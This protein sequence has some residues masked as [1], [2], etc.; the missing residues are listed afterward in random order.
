[1]TAYVIAAIIITMNCSC[2]FAQ[3]GRLT[4]K[5]DDRFSVQRGNELVRRGLSKIIEKTQ[6]MEKVLSNIRFRTERKKRLKIYYLE[7]IHDGIE[8]CEKRIRYWENG[9]KE[10]RKSWKTT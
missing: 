4:R 1:M 8:I 9:E 2:A 10:G 7:K 3:P 6:T 5:H